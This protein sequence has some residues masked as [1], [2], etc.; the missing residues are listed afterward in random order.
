MIFNSSLIK[1]SPLT[2][3]EGL[4]GEGKSTVPSPPSRRGKI[5]LGALYW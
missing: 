1:S 3:G 5:Q 4:G 2:M